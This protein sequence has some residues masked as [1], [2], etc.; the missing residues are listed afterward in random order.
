MNNAQ[1]RMTVH[2]VQVPA[3][4][5][6][7]TAYTVL[8]KAREQLL[9]LAEDYGRARTLAACFG[10]PDAEVERLGRERELC[11]DAA[12]SLLKTLSEF[13]EEKGA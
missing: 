9:A 10:A 1:G 6:M 12:G 11:R 13:A 8:A 7:L 5:P 4:T 2:H 3:G